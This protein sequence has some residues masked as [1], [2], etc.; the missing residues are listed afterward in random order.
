MAEVKDFNAWLGELPHRHKVLTP[1]NHE[2]YLAEDPRKCS[3]LSNA[4]VLIDEA[5]EIE[6]LK[7]WGSPI[8]PLYGV[9]F[10]RSSPA[11]RRRLYAQIPP[12]TDVIITHGPPHAILDSAPGSH[13]HAGD[14]ELLEAVLRIRPR[15][16]IFGH[17]H[18][19]GVCEVDEITFINAALMG[20]DGDLAAGPLVFQMTRR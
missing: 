7:I 2:R 19:Q 1:G 20:K 17:V 4:T 11:D 12:D 8:T 13:V 14:P 16:H 5:V 6:G 9:A 10:G 3:M 18:R 15:M